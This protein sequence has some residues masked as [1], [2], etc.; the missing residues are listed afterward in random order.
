VRGVIQ[1]LASGD[2]RAMALRIGPELF[3]RQ[4]S[5]RHACVPVGA[6]G[7]FIALCCCDV[8]GVRRGENDE[9]RVCV[10]CGGGD[11]LILGDFARITEQVAELCADMPPFRALAALL[12]GLTADDIDVLESMENDI[13]GLEDGLITA[14]RPVKGASRRIIALRRALMRMKRYYDQL[15]VT[16]DELLENENGAIP[17]DALVLLSGLARRVDRLAESVAHLSECV[18]QA[19]EAYQ[20]QIDIEQNQIMKRLTLLGTVFM[21]LTLIAGWYGMN[22]SMPE[23][24][25]GGGYAYVT[26]LSAAVCAIGFV[27]FRRK[28]WF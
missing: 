14:Q 27:L 17:D 3:E 6:D 18:A 10:Y 26:A 11:M 12:S 2:E 24:G 28:G 19:R 16:L 8:D 9:T 21:P 13:G 1:I 4:R 25:W 5:S 20:A 7:Y 23:Y 15:D 22:F